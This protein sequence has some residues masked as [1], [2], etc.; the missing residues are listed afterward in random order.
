MTTVINVMVTETEYV[1]MVPPENIEYVIIST[2]AIGPLVNT[3][4]SEDGDYLPLEGGVITG[5]IVHTDSID[6]SS[7]RRYSWAIYT[8]ANHT[9]I[10]DTQISMVSV[11][12]GSLYAGP[13]F[14]Y[15]YNAET[16]ST[17][18]SITEIDGDGAGVKVRSDGKIVWHDDTELERDSAGVLKTPGVIRSA[19]AVDDT[20]LVNI[21]AGNA[22]WVAQ[23]VN[24][25]APL[26]GG[27]L[28]ADAIIPA[29]IA[30]DSEIAAAVAAAVA[31]VIGTAPG[32]LDALGEISDAIGDDPNF[33]ITIAN[34][35]ATK[36][37]KS[38]YDANTIL[39]AN[40]DDTPF[41]MTVGEAT[42]VGRATGGN[43]AALLPAQVRTIIDLSGQISATP[44]SLLP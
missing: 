39:V 40:A 3:S 6:G 42:I 8:E 37:P 34:S 36:V 12:R 11:G 43:I 25:F 44:R 5:D 27:G 22:L 7:F 19:D 10:D 16:N 13:D 24:G 23:T 33:A 18:I 32:A 35:L 28:I 2:T 17:A 41:A 15:S 14:G 4:A 1:F 26:D 30:R 29:T 20:D 21:R 31:G 38:L 9:T